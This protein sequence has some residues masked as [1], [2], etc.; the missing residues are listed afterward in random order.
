MSGRARRIAVILVAAALVL[1][2]G[3]WVSV[4]LTERLW[5]SSVSEAVAVAGARHALLSLTLEL[6]VLFLSSAWFVCNLAIAARVALPDRAPPERLQARLWPA[7]LPRWTLYL[8]GV[9][10]GVMLGSGAGRWLDD[11]LLTFDGVRFGVIDPLMGV[12]LGVFLRD[13]PLWLELQRLVATLAAVGLA[14]VL[15]IHLAG[16]AMTVV[17]RR[18]WISPKVRGHLAIL[19]AV[20]AVAVAWGS[21]LE[22][23]R[24]AA[25]LRGP[26][27]A[28]E[29]M[30]R[31]LVA[32]I[33]AGIAA[34]AAIAS[35]LWWLRVRAVAAV[36][37]WSLLLLSL[38]AGRLLPLGSVVATA[39][40]GWRTA[41]R[42]LDSV[43]FSLGDSGG[44]ALGLRVPAAELTPTLWDEAMIPLAA[45]TESTTVTTTGRGWVTASGRA[46][47]VWFAVRE[48]GVQAPALLAL[49]DD[50]VSASGGILAWREGDTATSPGAASYRE[51]GRHALRPTSP[52]FDVSKEARGTTLD[53][54]TKRLVLAWALQVPDAISS[55]AGSRMGW[56]LD[57]AVRLRA[58]APFAVWSRPRPRITGGGVIWTSDGLLTSAFFPSS[59]QIEWIGRAV[60]MVRSAFLGTV[61]ASTGLVRIF[62]R[63]PSDSLAAAWARITGP[64][65]EAPEALAPE[66]R[67]GD[68][69][70]EEL[71][72]AQS[73]VL[74]G[75][76]WQAGRLEQAE[77]GV[78]LSPVAAAGGSDALVPLIREVSRQVTSF[79]LARRTPSG[80]SVRLIRLDS[81]LAV[82]SSA[83]LVEKWKLFPFQQAIY[84]SVRASG[85][86]FE[87]GRVRHAVA[88]DGIAA[89]QPA[90]SVPSSGP[91]Q[92]VV[93]NVMLG[94]KLGTGRSF[95]EAWR[96]L[97]G[98]IGPLV[99]GTGAEAVLEE[100]RRWM[101]HADSAFKRGDFQEMGRALQFLRELLEPNRKR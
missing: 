40:E 15:T 88:R 64:L 31:S 45:M 61:D 56:R 93:V 99:P 84:D 76:A 44:T 39:D 51:L 33:Q 17:D 9:L 94:S 101:R 2:A 18:V 8:T 5:E 53:T 95:P 87:P 66:L 43:A 68:P 57:P 49:A 12:D 81:T 71:L 6:L 91:A 82:E 86:R 26:M 78:E 30:L 34:A 60:S 92:L 35:I 25:G 75:P 59:G 65:I 10:L 72:L 29:F 24:F 41:A 69:Y 67:Y 32:Q 13:F 54:W 52:A 20:L 74:Q 46:H 3:R 22:E 14:A 85:G 89:Y 50:Q 83:S 58:T 37:I 4:F 79:L 28:S 36:A 63:D 70:P 42:R 38:V 16:G 80:D 1:S 27:V 19:L 98:E 11:L 97:R 47:P 96:N 23:F 21:L 77:N 73:R 62:R 7:R 55:P 90:W 48:G 100:A